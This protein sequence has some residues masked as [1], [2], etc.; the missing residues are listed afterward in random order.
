MLG[1]MSGVG[2]GAGE[3]LGIRVLAHFPVPVNGSYTG[4]VIV[5][6]ECDAARAKFMEHRRFQSGANAERRVYCRHR[7]KFKAPQEFEERN[8]DR[9]NAPVAPAINPALCVS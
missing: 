3:F 1:S 8:Y 5:S 4:G 2:A 6:E 7:W 9:W